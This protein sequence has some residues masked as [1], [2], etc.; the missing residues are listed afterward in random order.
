[1][2]KKLWK[3]AAVIMAASAMLLTACGG[4]GDN[5][6]SENTEAQEGNS[7]NAASGESES[8]EDLSLQKVKDAG[9]F[10]LGLDA[11]FKPMGYTDE[12]NEIVGFDIDL[13]EA[14]CEKLGVELV[15]EPINWD[16]KEQD[17]SVGKIDC[18]W[19]GLSVSPSREEAFNLSEPYM[20]NAMVFV[21]P[22]SSD[23][24]SVDDLA[25]K[26][27]IVQNGSTAQDTL[28]A[29]QLAANM[30]ISSIATN[31]EALQQMD[32]NLVDAVFM[33]EVVAQYEIQNSGKAYRILDEGLSEEE[34][35]IAFRKED[36][37]LRDEVQKI[38]SE[39]KADGTVGEIS[40]KWFG[41]DI[42]TIE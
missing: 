4:T 32:I 18:I 8:G 16:T 15:K 9:K 13:A 38:L 39:L 14:V 26:K 41:S 22:E 7:S 29:S 2:R 6:S 11:T 40:T 33:D 31:V 24:N 21:V 25:G 27:V 10:V 20:K 23:I 30:E 3:T 37:A 42:T 12:N 1:M 34:Y 19:N 35:A 5:T 36:Q 17:L 28:A